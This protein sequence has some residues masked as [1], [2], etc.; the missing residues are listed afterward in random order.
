MDG[1]YTQ[2]RNNGQEDG[3]QDHDGR[4]GIHKAA[5]EQ[6]NNIEP[7]SYTHLAAICPAVN[8]PLYK[9]HLFALL[10]AG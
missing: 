4:R 3:R 6:K 1:L 2:T 10:G 7:V 5:H 9:K 8:V